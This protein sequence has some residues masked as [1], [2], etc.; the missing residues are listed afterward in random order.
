MHP[1]PRKDRPT[2]HLS[3]EE[4]QAARV[5]TGG[6]APTPARRARRFPKAPP[7]YREYRALKETLRPA[8]SAGPR[9]PVQPPGVA[10]CVAGNSGSSVGHRICGKGWTARLTPGHGGT[11]ARGWR[12]LCPRH[13]PCRPHCLLLQVPEPSCWG[14]HLNRAVTPGL[15]AAAA[16]SPCGSVPDYGKRLKA[17]LKDALQAGPALRRIP[18]RPQR[19]PPKVPSP[20]LPA[21]G[22]DPV[23]PEEVSEVLP[24][25]PRAQLRPGRLQQLQESLSLRLG[26]L[27]PG[28]LQRCHKETQ[29]FLGTSEAC[30]PVL[31]TEEP[32]PLTSGVPS[33]PGP[34]TGP[35]APFLGSE[36]PAMKVPGVSAGNP[37]LGSSQDKKRRKSGER[38]GTAA[39]QAPQHSSQEGSLPEAAGAVL[40]AEECPGEPLQAQ[41]LTGPSAPRPAVR[42]RGNYVRLNLKQK[43]YVRGPA[44]RGRLLRKQ[45]W[46]QKW[47]K[48]AEHLGGGQPNAP[49]KDSC[50]RCGQLGHW[51]SQCPRPGPKPTRVPKEE[52]G[53]DE[54]DRQMLPTLAA[55]AQRTHAACSQLRGEEDTGPAGSELLV[56]MEAPVPGEPCPSPAVPPLYLPGPLGQVA[57]TP[58]EVLQALEQLGHRAFRPG[59]EHAVM[60]ILSGMSTLLVLPTGAGKSLCYQLP[61]LLYAQR[62]PCLTLVISPLLSLM[63]DQV[64]GLPR[65]L[66]AACVHSGMTRKQ[67][68]SALQRARAGQVH[69]LMLSPEALVGAGTGSPACLT[70]L[71][72]VAFV[73]IDEA[74]CLSQW[75]HNFRPCYLR[76]CKVLRDSLGVR[77]FLGLTATATR[78]TTLDVAEHLGIAKEGVLRGPVTIPANLHLSVSMDRDPDQALVTLLQ[79]DR[80]RTLDSVIIY[81]NRREDTERVSALLRTCL[82][83]A[84][85]PGPGGRAPEAVAEAYHAGM[86]SRERRRVQRAFMEGRLRVVVA[87]VA[88]G[89]GLDRPDVRAVL[90]LG[91]PPSF[92]SYIQAVGRAGRD[93]QPAH[94]H[95]FLQPQGEDLRELRRHVHANAIDFLAV[96][97][98]VQRA[99]PPCTCARRQSEQEGGERQEGGSSKQPSHEQTARCPGHKRALPVQPTVQA[100]DMPEEVIE[101]LLCY[102]ELH[103]QHWLEL[104]AP[105]YTHCC[106]RCP[107]GPTQ[108]QA[109]ASRCVPLAACLAQQLPG[110]TGGGSSTVEFD[111]VKLVDSMGWELAPVR[112]ALH[113]LQWNPEPRKGVPRGTGVLVEFSELAF[114][115]HSPGDLT[116]QEKDQICGFLHDRVQAR[117][118]EALAC[119]RLM[120][121]A[122]HSVAFPS[123]GPCLEKPDDDRSTRLKALLGHY[124]EEEGPGGEEAAQGPEPGQA[125]LQDWED[126]IRR[127]VRHF[128][129][130]WPEQQFSGRA[131]ARIFHGIGSPCFPAQVY[132]RDRRFWRKYLHLNFHALIKLATEEILL[133]GR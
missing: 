25:L 4:T 56:P 3:R 133:W 48:K 27:D 21:A 127:D 114:Y 84:R 15:P 1:S 128:L 99:F 117:E 106:V 120:F 57:A 68:D 53:E 90:H 130:S 102:L 6:G 40:H 37:L 2:E 12:H 36:A 9:V 86:C 80:F 118:R 105:T 88:F 47:K 16:P 28:W 52:G 17:N 64:S 54:D 123:C 55:V 111:L 122:F 67:R 22:A 31:S 121:R 23:S 110:N 79:G 30:Q 87:T 66:K 43:R 46:K 14:S 35:E 129:S 124:F 24:Q 5:V 59:Q 8:S 65:G 113:Q 42:D 76:V 62:S 98:L 104:L 39:A 100:L 108:L 109:L 101:T 85:A 72:P 131:V 20:G 95:L 75:S 44:L 10:F 34:S 7:L 78:S 45:A 116:A 73:C 51:A 60:R 97:K 125:K 61:A 94:C 58:V 33:G 103:P 26:S 112:K 29:S 92:E 38:K 77:C 69:V 70:Q 50:F 91:L 115:L 93:G 81:C 74:H 49:V 11:G 132:G 19:P 89:M 18:R 119:L 82:P 107:G 96:K 71:P 32:P 126:Q 83:E 13:Q 63:D 41:L